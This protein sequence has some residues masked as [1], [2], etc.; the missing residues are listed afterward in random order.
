MS[1]LRKNF[2]FNPRSD[3]ISRALRRAPTLA[4]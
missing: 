4:S 3:L 2:I 1:Q